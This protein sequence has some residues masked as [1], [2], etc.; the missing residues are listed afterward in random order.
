MRKTYTISNM[1][2]PACE[3]HL[4]ELEDELRGI[5]SIQASYKKQRLE[6]EFDEKTI[7]EAQIRAAVKEIGYDIS[8]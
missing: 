3:M 1:V 2:C 4:E 5:L 6:V 7:S 8:N